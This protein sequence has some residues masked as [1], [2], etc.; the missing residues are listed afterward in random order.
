MSRAWGQHVC[1]V[2]DAF[3]GAR[4]LK[5][6]MKKKGPSG[7]TV[8]KRGQMRIDTREGALQELTL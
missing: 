7:K 6:L 3:N 2:L 1:I 8:V 4:H 5:L